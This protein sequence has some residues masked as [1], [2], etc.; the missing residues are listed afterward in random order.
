MIKYK[1]LLNNVGESLMIFGKPITIKEPQNITIGDNCRMNEYIFIHG[2]GGI[3]IRNDVTLSAY[4]K[5]ISC[6]YDTR[7]WTKNY[8]DKKHIGLQIYIGE[9]TWIG[10]GATILPG[11]EIKAKGVIIAAG[12]IVT[13]SIHENHVLVAGNP[14]KIIKSYI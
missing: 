11:V 4:C 7:N 12:S 10:A 3:I 1:I 13:K 5:L 2:G 9:G 8:K 6:T 14:A